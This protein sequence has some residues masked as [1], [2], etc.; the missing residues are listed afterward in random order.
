[1]HGKKISRII[2]KLKTAGITKIFY[3]KSR[4]LIS[5]INIQNFIEKCFTLH[6]K[7]FVVMNA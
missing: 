3:T 7:S 5:W 4:I 6:G 1:M 2:G